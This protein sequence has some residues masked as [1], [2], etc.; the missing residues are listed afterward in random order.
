MIRHNAGKETPLPTYLDLILHASTRKRELIDMLHKLGLSISYDR[1]LQISAE[2]AYTIC[3]LYE[4]EGVVCPPN[5]KKHVLTTAAVDNID[6]NPSSTTAS[7]GR[8][9]WKNLGRQNMLPGHICL[10]KNYNPMKV[11]WARANPTLLSQ[12]PWQVIHFMVQL[13][14]S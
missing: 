6:H 7:R 5:L 8:E 13:F 9:G 12:S 4:E 10:E 2:L 1:V 3:T 11:G 14:L